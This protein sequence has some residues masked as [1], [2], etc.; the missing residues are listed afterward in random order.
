QSLEQTSM[1]TLTNDEGDRPIAEI[2]GASVVDFALPL[3][4]ELGAE[5]LPQ[6][7][8]GD[9]EQEG[10]EGRGAPAPRKRFDTACKR[11]LYEVFDR[12]FAVDLVG[13]KPPY[14]VKVRAEQ[15]LTGTMVAFGPGLE[16]LFIV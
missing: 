4:A 15:T 12:R 16:Q 5:K 7:V 8:V 1:L 14:R 10:S 6:Y 9:A 3:G 2:D 11:T 13:K